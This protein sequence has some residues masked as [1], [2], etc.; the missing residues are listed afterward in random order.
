M[1]ASIPVLAPTEQTEGSKL[2]VLRWLKDVGASVVENE[3]LIEIETDKVTVEVP[4]PASGV[5]REILRRENDEVVE[6][7]L[8]SHPDFRR[9]GPGEVPDSIERLCDPG[10]A[11]RTYPHRD[12][13]DG[14]FAVR[15]RRRL[16]R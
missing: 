2:Q 5:L 7:F 16:E 12:G 9:E 4:A 8:A 15:M 6:A 3:P 14:F 10:A 1:S 11:L 13:L